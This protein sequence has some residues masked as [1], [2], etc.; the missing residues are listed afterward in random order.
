MITL[1]SPEF[2]PRAKPARDTSSKVK[3]IF[4]DDAPSPTLTQK[5]PTAPS[6]QDTAWFLKHDLED[7]LSYDVK[8]QVKGGTLDALVER[9]TRHDMMDSTFNQ[10][11]L[12]TFKSFT[13]AEELFEKLI[14]RFNIS[15]PPALTDQ[16]TELWKEKVQFPIRFR[17]LNTIKSW[18]NNFYTG[19]PDDPILR[20]IKAWAEGPLRAAFPSANS[21]T[22]VTSVDAQMKP[23]ST[24]PK[25]LTMTKQSNVP[26]PI[27]PKKLPREGKG[28]KLLD[29]HP[30]EITRQITIQQMNL[31][32]KIRVVDCLDKAWSG[33]TASPDNNIKKMIHHANKLTGWAAESILMAG[34]IKR[35]VA[36]LK[37]W[38]QIAD[39]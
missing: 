5:T 35:R 19:T 11:F 12:L 4:G 25:V 7:D 33:D 24:V 3:K 30:L 13:T 6:A 32:I 38:V 20:A 27:L 21:Q 18:M 37:H 23:S 36:M 28:L 15:P 26:P 16:E 9:L 8:G 14:A 10:T 29:V 17:V 2:S 22:L 31:Y 34:D 1:G 39:V